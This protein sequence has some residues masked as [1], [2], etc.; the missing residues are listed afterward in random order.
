MDYFESEE[1][2]DDKEPN[3]AQFN[4]D[5]RLSSLQQTVKSHS[6]KKDE[7]KIQENEFND[8]ELQDLQQHVRKISPCQ[9]LEDMQ[10]HESLLNE[11]ELNN[12][13]QD[14][15]FSLEDFKSLDKRKIFEDEDCQEDEAKEVELS[16]KRQLNM[17]DQSLSE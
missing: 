7:I 1:G 2:V 15:R 9:E 13:F 17:D 11:S 10:S 12:Y 14:Q 3:F 6:S 8:E 16:T 4:S 5:Q